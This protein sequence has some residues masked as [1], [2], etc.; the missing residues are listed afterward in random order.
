[1]TTHSTRLMPVVVC[2]IVG[3]S[4]AAHAKNIDLPRVR[5][6]DPSLTV[7]VGAGSHRSV[8][9]HALVHR[10]EAGDVVVYLQYGQLPSGLQGRLTFLTAAAGLRYVMVEVAR[11]LDAPRLI[12][13]VGHELQ[14]A[15]EILEQ[16][17]IVSQATFASAYERSGFRRRQFADGV[18]GFDTRAAVDVGRQVWRELAG[19]AVTLATR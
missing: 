8:T 19:S 17:Q 18:V 6:L 1:M 13:I 12:A 11:E 7:V 9:F 15:V 10:L 14:H 4:A 2:L 16:A 5:P 3:L